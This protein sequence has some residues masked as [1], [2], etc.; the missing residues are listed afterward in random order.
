MLTDKHS[1]S[2]LLRAGGVVVL[3]GPALQS[4]LECAVLAITYR[5]L[6]TGRVSNR[7]YEDLADA[8]QA[9]VPQPVNRTSPNQPSATLSQ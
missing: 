4:A 1:V 9:A 3:T 7:P 6:A 5:S 8:L 2:G